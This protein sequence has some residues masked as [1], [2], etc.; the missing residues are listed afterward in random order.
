M[1]HLRS[2]ATLLLAAIL[3]TALPFLS[4]AQTV[5]DAAAATAAEISKPS[6]DF[7]MFQFTYE[8]WNNKPDSIKTTGIGRGFNAYLCY[9][10]PIQKSHFS[11]AAGVGVGSTNIYL[12]N[13]QINLTDTGTRGSQV[14]FG[15]E[16]TDY[17]K[18]KITVAYLEAPFELRYFSNRANRNKGFKAAIGLRAGLLV[19]AHT[20]DVRTVDGTKVVDKVNTRRYMD[21]YRFS[22][23]VRIGYG[24]FSLFGSYNLNPLFAEGSGPDI[25][26]Y[27][28]GLCITGL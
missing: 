21:K 28:I 6:R 14:R 4:S 13:Q 12:D 27:S 23:T 7:L 3:C 11:F 22:T 10:F 2:G 17:S 18:Y 16:T 25:V 8:G 15:S 20:K 5:T 9:D 19:G 26:P 24:N 1:L